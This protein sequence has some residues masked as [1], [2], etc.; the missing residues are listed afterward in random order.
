M[1]KTYVY[2]IINNEISLLNKNIIDIDELDNKTL[3]KVNYYYNVGIPKNFE[4]VRNIIAFN[5]I[6]KNITK[7]Y[8]D[9]DN[10]SIKEKNKMED[11]D[12]KNDNSKIE[13][14]TSNLN[15]NKIN[16]ANIINKNLYSKLNNDFLYGNINNKF[17]GDNK[18][19]QQGL[20]EQ[21][22]N[23]INNSLNNSNNFR[24]RN[25]PSL[26][27]RNEESYTANKASV[28]AS[29]L[30]RQ[31]GSGNRGNEYNSEK[32]NTQIIKNK[33][34]QIT[35]TNRSIASENNN[36]YGIKFEQNGIQLQQSNRYFNNNSQY[37]N[38]DF[39]A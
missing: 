14:K 34:P 17:L 3:E 35:K 37:F 27:E 16:R 28:T 9:F 36:N 2:D 19:K 6:D 23:N 21:F 38:S 1:S 10:F 5:K 33:L 8:F 13:I 22:F 31:I 24:N 15:V 4:K 39:N 25:E 30:E 32:R 7:I 12:S 18:D 29:S 20:N 11:Y 26:I